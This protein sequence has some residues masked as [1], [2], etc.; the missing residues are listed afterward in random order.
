MLVRGTAAADDLW[1]FDDSSDIFHGRRGDDTIS[2]GTGD[3]AFGEDGN[4]RL[5]SIFDSETIT[6]ATN[7]TLIGGAGNDELN[8][9]GTLKGGIGDDRLVTAAYFNTDTASM[10]GGRGADT[11][12]P[13]VHIDGHASHIDIQD[14]A[15]GRD[16]LELYLSYTQGTV[17]NGGLLPN[18]L[19]GILDTNG[20]GRL[21]NDVPWDGNSAVTVDD[22]GLTIRLHEDTVTLHG[23]TSMTAADWQ[24]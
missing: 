22:S 3:T 19:F 17:E 20:D 7:V 11:F 21:G 8:G 5:R 13:D 12:A 18:Q 9:F 23:I 4:D 16:H 15:R 14:F 6:V 10:H 1:G 2:V 24:F